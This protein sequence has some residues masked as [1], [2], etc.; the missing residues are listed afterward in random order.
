M[1]KNKQIIILYR[2]KQVVP[3]D[4]ICCMYHALAGGDKNA[5]PLIRYINSF[6]EEEEWEY[7][8]EK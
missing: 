8:Y 7:V 1:Q 5:A 6:L 2:P 3:T 4:K